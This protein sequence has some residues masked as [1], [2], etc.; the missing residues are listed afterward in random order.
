MK[1]SKNPD[2]SVKLNVIILFY[3]L[4]SSGI[5]TWYVFVPPQTRPLASEPLSPNRNFA[6]PMFS[7]LPHSSIFIDGNSA[8][9]SNATSESWPGN[10]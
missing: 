1:L 2:I 10:G 8:F 7:Y 3:I 5:F 9:I 6:L 4:V